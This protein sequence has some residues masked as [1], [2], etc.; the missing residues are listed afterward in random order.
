M[1]RDIL[2]F[3]RRGGTVKFVCAMCVCVCGG[4]GGGEGRHN[5][6]AALN[7]GIAFFLN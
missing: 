1:L 3:I 4:G 2:I 7:G 5:I 6:F